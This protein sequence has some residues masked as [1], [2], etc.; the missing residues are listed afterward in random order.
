M[1]LN[2]R[3]HGLV[4]MSL[5]ISSK[6]VHWVKGVHIYFLTVASVLE[7]HNWNNSRSQEPFRECPLTCCCIRNKCQTSSILA[8]IFLLV[9]FSNPWL[10]NSLSFN[11]QEKYPNSLLC[12]KSFLLFHWHVPWR[13]W[14]KIM[15]LFLKRHLSL[16]S[17]TVLHLPRKCGF[18]KTNNAFA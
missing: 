15:P 8:R 13:R 16:A 10:L 11:L 4:L 3:A 5:W 1:C 18:N 6:E 2:L 14:L 17:S 12:S 7:K 9:W